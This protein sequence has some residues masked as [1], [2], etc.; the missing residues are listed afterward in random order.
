MLDARFP[1]E[2]SLIAAPE[3]S[4]STAPSFLRSLAPSVSVWPSTQPSY[5]PSVEPTLSETSER[6]FGV[7]LII[8]DDDLFLSPLPSVDYEIEL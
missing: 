1:I 2:I 4:I 3:D 7:T 5:I 6:P 8:T